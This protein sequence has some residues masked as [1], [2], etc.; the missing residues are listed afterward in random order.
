MKEFK[1]RASQIGQIMTDPRTKAAKDA[2][3]LSETAKSYC[4]TWLK[5]Q[6]YGRRKEFSSKFTEKGNIVEDN[7]IDFV[8]KQL[9]L[10]FLMKNDQYYENDYITG[11]PDV[12]VSSQSLIID[13]K[14]SW[15][16][17]TFPL[18]EDS[19]PNRAYYWQAQ[20]YM[21][22][23]GHHNFKLAYVL[24]DTPLHLIEKEAYWW[25]KNNGYDD[26]DIEVFKDFEK[27]MTYSGIPSKYKLKTFDIVHE[28]AEVERVYERVDQCRIY[29]NELKKSL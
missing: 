16:C 14:N 9:G 26:L 13:V 18:F 4:E 6:L 23:T 11:T 7:S 1:I 19:L 15:D 3:E 27:R 21:E 29:I 2:G 22:L 12:I 25:C 28:R 10:G 24:S 17:F 5:E 20:G 8:A